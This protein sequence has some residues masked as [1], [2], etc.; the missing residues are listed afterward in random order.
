MR[1][2]LVGAARRVAGCGDQR[3]P[4]VNRRVPARPRQRLIAVR[5]AF[6]ARP[7]RCCEIR[8]VAAQTPDIG[9]GPL[10]S[11]LGGTPGHAVWRPNPGS[12]RVASAPDPCGLHALGLGPRHLPP[13]RHRL[14]RSVS[15]WWSGARAA[16][17]G[18]G[19]AGEGPSFRTPSLTPPPPPAVKREIRKMR[20]FTGSRVSDMTVVP[21][22]IQR[23]SLHEAVRAEPVLK[24][25]GDVLVAP[26]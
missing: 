2:P 10:S 5:A 22:E 23:F 18:S 26:P 3:R 25:G 20:L 21:G 16:L 1:A 7:V 24:P 19:D 14:W 6:D 11:P 8:H 15:G 13:R 17:E 12:C 9:H 4:H